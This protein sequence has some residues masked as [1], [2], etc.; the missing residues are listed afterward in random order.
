VEDLSRPAVVLDR[1]VNLLASAHRV[2]SFLIMWEPR[3]GG[4]GEVSP[5]SERILTKWLN[6]ADSLLLR[7]QRSELDELIARLG[8]AG[9]FLF[10][11]ANALDCRI[12][13]VHACR[14]DVLA[15]HSEIMSS[16]LEVS[17]IEDIVGISEQWH[18]AF[19]D[20]HNQQRDAAIATADD[21]P[22]RQQDRG[23][24]L[25]WRLMQTHRLGHEFRQVYEQHVCT[26]R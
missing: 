11:L 23:S 18:Q 3:H 14:S 4:A 25:A 20:D 21:I 26:T 17:P 10:E 16:W 9:V 6:H 24:E 5:E 19:V 13:D 22:D 8:R 12:R 2:P 7:G 15:A 1:F